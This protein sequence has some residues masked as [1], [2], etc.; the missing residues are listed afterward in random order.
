MAYQLRF[1]ES[2]TA[3]LDE[4]IDYFL[5]QFGDPM[6]ARSFLRQVDEAIKKLRLYADKYPFCENELLKRRGFRR[7]R[8]SS[9]NY[10]IFYRVDGDTVIIDVICH[11]LR[12]YIGLLGNL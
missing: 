4:C 3:Q 8:L 10:K 2:F 7:I 5:Y 6:V 1:T 12:D 11:D 9:Y